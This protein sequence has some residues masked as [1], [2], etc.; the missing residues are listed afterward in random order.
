MFAHKIVFGRFVGLGCQQGS[1]GDEFDLQGHQV[2]EDARQGHHHVDAGATQIRQRNQA[3]TD[4][5]AIAVKARFGAVQTQYLSDLAA[6]GFEVVA[7][8]Q[9]HGD[10]LGKGVA[11]L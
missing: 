5:A 4:Q 10:R 6:L 1:F 2:A 8:P 9:H 11:V 3:G 7:A